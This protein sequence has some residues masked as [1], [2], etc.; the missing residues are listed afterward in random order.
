LPDKLAQWTEVTLS[1]IQVTTGSVQIG[2]YSEGKDGD[3]LALDD[4]SLVRE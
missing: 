1:G 2:V 3:W 4:F